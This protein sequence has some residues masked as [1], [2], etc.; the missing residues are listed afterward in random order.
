LRLGILVQDS[1]PCEPI[2]EAV[3][4][5]WHCNGEGIYSGFESASQGSGGGSES[6]DD[7]TYLRGA[8]VTNAVASWSS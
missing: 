8:Q 3:V 4:D 5:V 2:P 6:T 7:E 1:D